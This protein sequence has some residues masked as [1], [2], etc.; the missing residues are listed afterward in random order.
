MIHALELMLVRL[1]LE[2]CW[3]EVNR[4]SC[5]AII[6]IGGKTGMRKFRAYSKCYFHLLNLNSHPKPNLIE[7]RLVHLETLSRYSLPG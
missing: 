7:G 3:C 2:I 4:D 6:W 1:R 5:F